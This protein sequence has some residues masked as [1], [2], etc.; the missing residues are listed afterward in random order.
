MILRSRLAD[1]EASARCSRASLTISPRSRRAYITEPVK[2]SASRSAASTG[3][4]R[5]S[6]DDRSTM[7]EGAA[8]SAFVAG[9]ISFNA[10][11]NAIA[12]STEFRFRPAGG[13]DI[14]SRRPL[15]RTTV[16]PE[17]VR[18]V[19]AR[20]QDGQLTM[21]E[22][23]VWGLVVNNLDAFELAGAAEHDEEALWEIIGQLSVASVNQAF[24]SERVSQL[25]GR[26][27]GM[28]S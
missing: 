5:R 10:L 12:D 25:L 28:L 11:R 23:S 18:R 3:R 13:I 2:K 14:T 19:L 1:R 24:T 22:V 4:E 17:D 15:P 7:T 8:L 21:E 9:T 16:R 26:I 20:Y 27:D 6:T